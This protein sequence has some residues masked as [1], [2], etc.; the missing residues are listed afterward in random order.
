MVFNLD[1]YKV[2]SYL[3]YY[4]HDVKIVVSDVDGTITKSD[5]LGHIIPKFGYDYAH[6]GIAPLFTDI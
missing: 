2:S 5:V 6:S 3:Y 1:G 4:K